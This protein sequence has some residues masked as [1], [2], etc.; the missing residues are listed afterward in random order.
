MLL[1]SHEDTE[2]VQVAGAPLQGKGHAQSSVA[3]G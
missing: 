3:G 1:F 2:D